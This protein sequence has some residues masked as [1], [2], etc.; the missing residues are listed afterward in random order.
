VQYLDNKQFEGL[1]IASVV[2]KLLSLQLSTLVGLTITILA[3][4]TDTAAAFP[5]LYLVRD[6]IFEPATG[7]VAAQLTL[8]SIRITTLDDGDNPFV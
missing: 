1:T 6:T 8:K 4:E 3:P 7:K 2:H 5:T